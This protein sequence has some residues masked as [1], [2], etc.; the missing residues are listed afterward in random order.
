MVGQLLL[1]L[2]LLALAELVVRRKQI[3]DQMA[4]IQFM[5]VY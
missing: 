5:A 3:R 1:Q 2:A 4:E